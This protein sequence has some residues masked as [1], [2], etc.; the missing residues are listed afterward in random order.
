MTEAE[1]FACENPQL[2]LR[3]IETATSDRKMR[4]FE[5]ACARRV[6]HRVNDERLDR[7]LLGMENFADGFISAHE[8]EPLHNLAW[9]IE[10]D[11][12]APS[13]LQLLDGGAHE[14]LP[15]RCGLPAARPRRAVDALDRRRVGK[16]VSPV[17]DQVDPRERLLVRAP[18]RSL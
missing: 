5:C 1:W 2:M 8:L 16:R 3:H 12:H 4:L 9:E 7:V 18:R 14:R 17:D 10:E 11:D 13:H 15:C 6:W